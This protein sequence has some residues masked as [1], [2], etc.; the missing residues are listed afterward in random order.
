MSPII[1]NDIFVPRVIYYIKPESSPVKIC[2][3]YPLP[4][5]KK[6]FVHF[7]DAYYII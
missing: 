7:L 2:P 5:E 4:A 3:V 6:Y 1:L